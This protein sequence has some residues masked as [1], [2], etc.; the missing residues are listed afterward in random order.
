MKRT[1]SLISL[2]STC[3][4]LFSATAQN[5]N[6]GTTL[7]CPTDDGT[8]TIGRDYITLHDYIFRFDRSDESGIIHLRDRRT[9][10]VAELD[11]RSDQ[12]IYFSVTEN[13]RTMQL[14]ARRSAIVMR[15]EATDHLSTSSIRSSDIFHES[16]NFVNLVR[17]GTVADLLH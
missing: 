9:E 1:I 5:Q 8:L 2:L 6:G 15:S 16:V 13:G 7:L 14:V 3:F 11:I 10:S 12:G 4:V 17:T